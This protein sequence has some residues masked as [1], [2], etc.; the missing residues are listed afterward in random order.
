MSSGPPTT[1]PTARTEA[2]SITVSRALMPSMRKSF[3]SSSIEYK[4]SYLGTRSNGST[5]RRSLANH[6]ALSGARGHARAES[7]DQVEMIVAA[8]QVMPAVSED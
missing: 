7:S 1:S 6:R 2:C 3:A 5:A 4:A 8:T